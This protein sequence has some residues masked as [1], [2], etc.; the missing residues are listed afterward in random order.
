MNTELQALYEQDQA[1]RS[2]FFEQLD[3]EQVQQ[4]LQR[5][6]A[7]RQ[8]VGK[9]VGS[10]ALQAPE[11]YFHAA[12]VFNAILS[13]PVTLLFGAGIGALGGLLRKR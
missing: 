11:D 13:I 7:R 8:R 3:H 6:R 5:D 2:V 9:L 4:V 1:D 12:M 10:E